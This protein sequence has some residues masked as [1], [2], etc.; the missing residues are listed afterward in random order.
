MY[1]KV[2][3]AHYSMLERKD[4]NGKHIE[5]RQHMKIYDKKNHAD[6]CSFSSAMVHS[7]SRFAYSHT[8]SFM[9]KEGF[10]L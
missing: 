7:Q 3:K 2:I 9:G 5:Y 1:S 4:D 8:E 10:C 6:G